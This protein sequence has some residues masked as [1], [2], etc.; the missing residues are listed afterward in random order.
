MADLLR[1]QERA[2]A[3]E[4]PAPGLDSRPS[5]LSGHTKWTSHT[6]PAPPPPE[7]GSIA[8]LGARQPPAPAA[9]ESV[10]LAELGARQ[11]PAPAAPE[12]VSLAELGARQAAAAAAAAA[13]P[14]GP[15]AAAA[16][17][18]GPPAGVGIVFKESRRNSTTALVV[19]SLAPGGPAEACGQIAVGDILLRVDGQ[20]VTTT[21]VPPPPPP[22][23]P[24]AHLSPAPYKPDAHLSPAP[25]KLDAHLS[26]APPPKRGGGARRTAR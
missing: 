8:E 14:A 22:Y 24:D 23:K 6:P 20:D 25:Y 19:K 7:S 10:S 12:S 18:A 11:P 17:P 21:E 4:S 26:P 3:A 1:R 15:P 16:A 9:P 13:A 5:A 2:H